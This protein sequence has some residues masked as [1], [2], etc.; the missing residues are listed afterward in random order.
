MQQTENFDIL[1]DSMEQFWVRWLCDGSRVPWLQ[2]AS[3]Y[4]KHDGDYFLTRFTRFSWFF[5]YLQPEDRQKFLLEMEFAEDDDLR[6]CMYTMNKEEIML[7]VNFPPI[8]LDY[9]KWPLQ[10][11]FLKTVEKTW[12]YIDY[13]NFRIVLKEILDCKNSLRDFDYCEL[14]EIFW[15]LSP[16][17]L[18]ESTKEDPHL[19]VEIDSCL[20]MRRK[21]EAGDKTIDLCLDEIRQKRENDLCLDEKRRKNDSFNNERLY[22]EQKVNYDTKRKRKAIRKNRGWHSKKP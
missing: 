4:F 9:L 11:L 13:M 15:N 22:W 8:L 5:P 18:K 3:E 20:E 10:N 2:G 21:R 16:S 14:F 1:Y 19:R 6:L 7:K 17:P 12:K